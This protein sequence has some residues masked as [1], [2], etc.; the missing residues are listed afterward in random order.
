MLAMGK[1]PGTAQGLKAAKQASDLGYVSQSS[2]AL[3]DLSNRYQTP[4]GYIHH[5]TP[6]VQ[7]G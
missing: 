7:I 3:S 5:R 6:T 2:I 4:P 1:R